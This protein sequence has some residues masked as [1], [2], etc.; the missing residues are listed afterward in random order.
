MQTLFI[1]KTG[2]TFASLSR[3]F[4]DFDS[5]IRTA[6]G[7]VSFP[8]I[9]VDAEKTEV[10]PA[11]EDCCGVIITGSHAMV[12][13]ALSWSR[14]LEAWIPSLLQAKI[15]LLGI[16]YGHQLLARAAGGE[17]G[18]HPRGPETGTVMLTRLPE[19]KGD[20]LLGSLPPSFPVHA[21]HAQTV[22]K[23]PDNAIRLAFSDHEANHAFRI[24][25][26]AWGVQFHPEYTEAIMQAYILEEK[27]RG[28]RNEST[29]DTLL[30]NVVATPQASELLQT[31]ARIVQK[32]SYIPGDHD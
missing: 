5:W 23:L 26:C 32:F 30:K 24:P 27:L 9:T 20:P 18:F 22:L 16:C 3:Q 10:L 13:D 15:P 6:L 29:T 1:I 7:P 4:G 14:I 2:S 11:A 31:F 12:T 19:S 28:E 25:P 8:V 21:T 17:A